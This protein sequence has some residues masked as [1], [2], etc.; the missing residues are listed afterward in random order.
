MPS[1]GAS[2]PSLTVVLV[3][4]V[5]FWLSWLRLATVQPDVGPPPSRRPAWSDQYSRMVYQR[6]NG[7]S[8]EGYEG[9]GRC[10]LRETAEILRAI[11][12]QVLRTW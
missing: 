11:R 6:T 8:T 3:M 2:I 10:R 5:P 7:Y 1:R 4:V 12:F 9:S